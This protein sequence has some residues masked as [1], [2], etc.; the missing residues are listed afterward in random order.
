MQHISYHQLHTLNSNSQDKTSSKEILKDGKED[1][2]FALLPLQHT[3]H[4]GR[5]V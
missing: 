4:K 5:Q 2:N 1:H 3:C